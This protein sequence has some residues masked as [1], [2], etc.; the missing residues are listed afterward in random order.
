MEPHVLLTVT[1]RRPILACNGNL[2]GPQEIRPLACRTSRVDVASVSRIDYMSNTWNLHRAILCQ[3]V[4]EN[5]ID[6]LP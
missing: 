6:E 2:E 1:H 5:V 3:Y 4:T